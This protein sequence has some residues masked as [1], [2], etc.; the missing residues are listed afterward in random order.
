MI[1][2][3][4]CQHALHPDDR[5]ELERFANHL[6]VAGRSHNT[7]RLYAAA[8]SRWLAVGGRP[9]HVDR[10][11]L[12][13]YLRHR[14]DQCRPATVN[15]DL[16]ALRAFYRHVS[17]WGRCSTACVEQIPRQL[18]VPARLPRY[19][20]VSEVDLA[21]AAI[22]VGT[23]LGLRDHTMI[24]L[25]FESGLRASEVIGMTTSSLLEDGT[26]YVLGKGRR[27]RYVPVS[28]SLAA[29]LDAYGVA[30]ARLRPGK[31]SAL[32]LTASSVPLRSG[33]SLWEIVQ[34]RLGA[35]VRAISGRRSW[36]G[37]YPHMLRAGFATALMRGGCPLPA[38]AQMLGHANLSTTAAY[39]GV[40]LE[41]LRAAIDRHPR[42]RRHDA[43][44]PFAR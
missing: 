35:G 9:G 2:N 27:E 3:V 1:T 43:T 38:I 40:E 17:A 13:Q 44:L 32:W 30:R 14:R 6:R 41:Q 31:R 18:R 5:A 11:L 4:Y 34:R 42:A 23:F 29:Q 22:D 16:Q 36:T 39:L 25:G 33:R 12:L 37:V 20:D 7:A 24:R 28:P 10:E 8:V 26:L 15:L 21:L 19:L